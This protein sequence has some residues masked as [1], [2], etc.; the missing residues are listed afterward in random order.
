ML[1]HGFLEGP[2]NGIGI[3]YAEWGILKGI[4]L[5]VTLSGLMLWVALIT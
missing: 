3:P 4:A 2:P 1:F 5:E